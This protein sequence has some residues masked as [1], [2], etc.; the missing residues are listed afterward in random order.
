MISI[1][2]VLLVGIGAGLALGGFIDI[3]GDRSAG[4]GT[5]KEGIVPDTGTAGVN[6]D[7]FAQCLNEKGAVMY[8]ASWCPH[9]QAEKEAFG[10]SFQYVNYVECTTD[11]DK[12]D[13]AG[14]EGVPTWI[15]ADG[16]KAVGTQGLQ[17][18]SGLTGCPLPAAE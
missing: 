7:A 3:G 6:L 8:G 1:V 2:A 15:L 16:T 4:V 10:T 9:C 18:L 11:Q 14:V 5:V 13:A 12:C 17:K